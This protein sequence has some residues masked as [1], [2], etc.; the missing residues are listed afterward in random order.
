MSQMTAAQ[1]RVIDPILTEVA[2][3]YRTNEAPIADLLFPI[4]PVGQRGGR[5]ISFGPEDFRLRNTAR[6]PGAATKRGGYGY[7][8][9]QFSLVDYS[10]EGEL[11]IE[12]LQDAAAVPGLDMAQMTIAKELNR[13]ALE[14]EKQC[15][16]LALNAASY[17]STNK[18]TLAS[19]DRWD[20]ANGD[21]FEDVNAAKEA[22][23]KQTG[24]RPNV[25]TL[26]PKVAT[27][28]R[29]NTKVL[30]R[31]STSMDRPPATLAQL[32]ALFEV[33]RVVEGGAVFH[34]GTDFT[35]VWGTFALL[36]YTTP[37]S[38]AEMG[39][40]NFGYTYQL[41][42]HPFAEEPYY[43]RNT[44]TWYFPVTDCRQPVLAGPS[45]GYLFTTAVN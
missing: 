15:A 41:Q 43:E 38:M 44:K 10:S 12:L 34:N 11:P 45:A 29:S 27:A 9:G 16:D 37:A 8:S 19:G 5:I 28:L 13:A 18:V 42:G 7:S 6:A 30:N 3:G 23:R 4:V 40:P 35:D 36:A 1:A 33:E 39:S 24:K 2:R 17:A 31:L 22:I 14:R 21:P 32:A 20:E 26:G 25:L